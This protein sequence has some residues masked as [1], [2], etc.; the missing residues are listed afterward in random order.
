SPMRVAATEHLD[1]LL[2]RMREDLEATPP[3]RETGREDRRGEE[4]LLARIRAVRERI[5][6]SRPPE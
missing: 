1:L 3:P 2:R 6:A 4:D 5:A